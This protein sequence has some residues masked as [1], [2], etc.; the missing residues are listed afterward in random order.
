VW[1][2][3]RQSCEMICGQGVAPAAATIGHFRY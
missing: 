1:S 2:E 3:A